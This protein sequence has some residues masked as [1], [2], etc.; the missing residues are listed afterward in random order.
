MGP[1]VVW[2]GKRA[3]AAC[4]Y[5]HSLTLAMGLRASRLSCMSSCVYV[6]GAMHVEIR[7]GLLCFQVFG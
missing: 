7:G 5:L 4:R 6:C 2:G 3:V 1:R